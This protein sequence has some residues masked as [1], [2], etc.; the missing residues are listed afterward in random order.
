MVK[1][2]LF[3]FSLFIFIYHLLAR[4]AFHVVTSYFLILK[5]FSI[6]GTEHGGSPPSMDGLLIFLNL[7]FSSCTECSKGNATKQ[8]R[9]QC[10]KA[11]YFPV[12]SS[13]QLLHCPILTWLQ[14]QKKTES[15]KYNN[16]DF[17]LVGS[18]LLW[19]QISA[20]ETTSADLVTSNSHQ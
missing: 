1:E 9:Y 12:A 3:Y 17:Q 16:S 19:A 11:L 20:K 6:L 7:L 15:F 10:R 5:N 13:A 4:S 14:G 2:V 18:L 8:S